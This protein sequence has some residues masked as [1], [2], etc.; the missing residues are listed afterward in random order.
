[1]LS[2]R[3]GFHAGNFA[4]VFKHFILVYLLNHLKTKKPFTFIDPFAGAGTYPFEDKFMQKNKEYLTGISKVLNAKITD[5]YIKDYLNLIHLANNNK[6][7]SLYPGAALFGLLALDKKDTIYLNELHSNEYLNLKKNFEGHRNVKID[8]TDAYSNLTKMIASS[9]GQ[10]LVL[11]D[12][13]YELK[14]EY[15]KVLKLIKHTHSQFKEVC[16]MI[17]YPDLKQ[18]KTQKFVD[19]FLN[20]KIENANHIHIELKNTN[21]RMQGTGFFIIN[22]LKQDKQNIDNALNELVQLFK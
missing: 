21:L 10:K 11:I 22:L 8:N 7:I 3:H 19:D 9:K 20:L 15:D 2:Y 14:N 18:D 16:Y 1:M 17:W 4:D 5:P 12:P 6:K 13:S